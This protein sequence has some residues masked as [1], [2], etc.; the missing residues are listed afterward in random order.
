[1][2]PGLNS[3]LL[4]PPTGSSNCCLDFDCSYFAAALHPHIMRKTRSADEI[5]VLPNENLGRGRRH[6][7]ATPAIAQHLQ[8]VEKSAIRKRN[9]VVKKPQTLANSSKV[10]GSKRVSRKY[11]RNPDGKVISSYIPICSIYTRLFKLIR[12]YSGNI[13]P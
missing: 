11:A 7:K 9:R 3:T 13:N 5:P 6:S 10:K 2:R 8:Q 1:M 4:Q 12:S